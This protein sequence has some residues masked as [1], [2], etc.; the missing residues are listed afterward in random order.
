MKSFGYF[1]FILLVLLLLFSGCS[2]TPRTA[3]VP[4]LLAENERDGVIINITGGNPGIRLI[5]IDGARIP[6]P[7]SG[8]HWDPIVYP[9]GRPINL[10]VHASFEQRNL[11]VFGQITEAAGAVVSGTRAVNREV[12]FYTPPLEPGGIYMLRFDKG[13]GIPGT[14]TLILTDIKTGQVVHTMEFG[15][16]W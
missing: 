16:L 10:I 11:P 6:A 7:A 1:G 4:Y 12:S 9:P 8:T 5:R 2:S 14:N 15:S 3:A 13:P